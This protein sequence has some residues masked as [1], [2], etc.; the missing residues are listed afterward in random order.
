[1]FNRHSDVVHAKWLE[2]LRVV[3]Q[4]KD[5]GDASSSSNSKTKKRPR[6]GKKRGSAPE[7][8]A[9]GKQ[10]GSATADDEAEVPPRKNRSV[11]ASSA[12]SVSSRR[13]AVLEVS[14]KESSASLGLVGG[15]DDISSDGNTADGNLEENSQDAVSSDPAEGAEATTAGRAAGEAT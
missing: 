8:S 14:P 7:E 4:R 2:Q 1:M 13:D 9:S 10:G 6:D 5:E 11:S 3:A 15:E 12:R